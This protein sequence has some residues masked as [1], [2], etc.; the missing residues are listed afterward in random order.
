MIYQEL[1]YSRSLSKDYRW[2]LIPSKISVET[3]KT[4]NQLYNMY[5][6][7]KNTFNKSP[8][9]PLYCLNHPETTSLVNCCLSEHKDKDGRGIYCLQ[10]IS[11]ARKYRRHFWFILPWIL[12]GYNKQGVLNTW[13]KIDFSHAD[14]IVHHVSEECS[15]KL[16]QLGE[17]IAELTKTRAS[18]S[19]R[20][21]VPTHELVYI[22]YNNEGLKELSHLI[23]SSY[24]NCTNFAFGATPEMIKTFDFKVIAR[25]GNRSPVKT[26]VQGTGT[27]NTISSPPFENQHEEV[28]TEPLED[29]VDRFDPRKKKSGLHDKNN[30]LRNRHKLLRGN[31]PSCLLDQVLPRI[32]SI[33]KIGKKLRQR[34]K[35]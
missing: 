14:E 2:M 31:T 7:Y 33:F 18:G 22:P 8:V 5:D 32:L 19:A 6:K 13:Q 15:L 34:F 9:S 12:D 21:R 26:S 28:I 35:D 23:S 10:G 20:E 30:L 24:H 3:L 25:V 29:P 16:D 27:T 1:L 11:V 17:S 4:L